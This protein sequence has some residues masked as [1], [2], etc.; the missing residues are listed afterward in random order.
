[1]RKQGNKF[2]KSLGQLENNIVKAKD[3]VKYLHYIAFLKSLLF[4]IK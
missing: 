4:Q 3:L 1:M 2:A